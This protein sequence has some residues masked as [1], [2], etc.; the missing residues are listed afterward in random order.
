MPKVS[1]IM[2]V[3]NVEKYLSKS[4]ESVVSQTLK[5]IEIILILIKI[6]LLILIIME[7][8]LK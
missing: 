2:P 5:D 6:H 8:Q 4:I 3:Y 7:K 1:I